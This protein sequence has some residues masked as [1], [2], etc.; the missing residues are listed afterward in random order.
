[1]KKYLLLFILLFSLNINAQND[2]RAEKLL[3]KSLKQD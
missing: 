1:M 3:S 2:P